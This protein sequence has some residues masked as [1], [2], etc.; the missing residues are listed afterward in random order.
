ML[1]RLDNTFVMFKRLLLCLSLILSN[2]FYF[3]SVTASAD[4]RAEAINIY[5]DPDF[6]LPPG[7]SLLSYYRKKKFTFMYKEIVPLESVNTTY[8]EI[9]GA[10]SEGYPDFY[11]GIQQLGDGTKAA[12]FSAWDVK[13]PCCA[14]VQPGS[15]PVENQV[16]VLAK[17]A[18]T[19]TRQFGGEG[20][21]MNSM[22]YN[23]DWKLNQK[24]SMLAAIEPAGEKSIISAAI[25]IGDGEWEFMTSFLVPTKL[26]AGMPGGVSFIEDFGAGSPTPQRRAMLVGPTVV[27]DEYGAMTVFTNYYVAASAPSIGHRITI[28]GSKL[29][30]ET[31]LNPQQGTKPDYRFILERPSSLPDFSAAIKLIESQTTGTSTKYQERLAREKAIQEEADLKAANALAEAKAK[32]DLEALAKAKINANNSN[33]QDSKA[34]KKTTITCIKGKLTKKVT[35][36]KPKCPIGYKQK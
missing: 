15:A 16:T 29:L 2:T 19:V 36:V 3:S 6:P 8:F 1:F 24:V 34:I 31:G 20:S 7:E 25:R 9:L 12:I 23:F 26:D 35:G 27:A 22:I 17:G 32:A 21:G 28:Q 10:N 4:Q 30:A 11:G 18:R 13:S 33:S 5:V 14:I